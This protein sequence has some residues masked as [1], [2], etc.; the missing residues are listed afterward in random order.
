LQ[1]R[2]DSADDEDESDDTDAEQP[3]PYVNEAELYL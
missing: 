3:A 1:R 2:P